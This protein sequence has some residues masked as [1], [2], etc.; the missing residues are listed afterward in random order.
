MYHGN[1]GLNKH[2]WQAH[3][4]VKTLCANQ[5]VVTP[6]HNNI[7]TQILQ[8]YCHHVDKIIQW[9]VQRSTQS[10]P[11]SCSHDIVLGPTSIR[12]YCSKQEG[13]ILLANSDIELPMSSSD[14]L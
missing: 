14:S 5:E 6:K 10:L 4:Q 11:I 1:K 12:D 3:Q 7:I 2:K 8:L 13:D 9:L